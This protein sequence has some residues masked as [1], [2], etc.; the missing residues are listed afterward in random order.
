MPNLGIELNFPAIVPGAWKN[1]VASMQLSANYAVGGRV[2]RFT[3]DGASAWACGSPQNH[4]LRG[5]VPLMQFLTRSI[6]L[7]AK[8]SWNIP[9]LSNIHANW[10]RSRSRLGIKF[11]RWS[12]RNHG[13]RIYTLHEIIMWIIIVTLPFPSQSS[14]LTRWWIQWHV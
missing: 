2:W 5:A 10:G 6:R 1:P 8:T 14:Q 3:R 9:N 7:H 12:S 11:P 4:T 13:S